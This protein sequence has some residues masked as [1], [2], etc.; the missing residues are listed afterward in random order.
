MYSSKKSN[1]IKYKSEYNLN[2]KFRYFKEFLFRNFGNLSLLFIVAMLVIMITAISSKGYKAFSITK[3]ALEV[4][5]SP[6]NNSDEA[7]EKY[8]SGDF[9]ININNALDNYFEEEIKKE[10]IDKRAIYELISKNAVVEINQQLRKNKDLYNKKSLFWLSVAS[11]VDLFYKHQ[12]LSQLSNSQLRLLTKFMKDEK[13]D[14][15]FNSNFF[16]NGDSRSPEIAGIFSG[17]L[18]SIMISAIFLLISFPVAIMAA[19]YLEEFAPKNRF[20]DIIEISINNLAAIPSITFGLLGL[21]LFVQI[22]DVPRASSLV[23]G[24]T[25]SMLIMPIIVI[26]TRNTIRSIP[27]SIRDA[28]IGLGASRTQL[29]LHHLLPLSMPGIMTGTI[30]AISRAIGETAPLLMIGM[31]AFVV[32]MPKDFLEPSTALPV[33]IYLWSDSP[34][35]GFAEKTAGAIMVLIALLIALNLTAIILR[36]KFTKKW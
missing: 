2:L 11:K 14:R 13:I 15:F 3:I 16:Y 28:A 1:K 7:K 4:D 29:A 17:L 23:A 31:I 36:K 33:Q 26:S 18:G 10:N 6:I 21:I 24:M 9:R 12:N 32:D 19:F 25:L 5:I 30:L 8:N 20:T 35:I 27:K 22:F 34:E